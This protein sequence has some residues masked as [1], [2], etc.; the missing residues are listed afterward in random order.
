MS[1][2][3]AMCCYSKKC[4]MINNVKHKINNKQTNK[5][6]KEKPLV[7]LNKNTTLSSFTHNNT[8][9]FLFFEASLVQ[10]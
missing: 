3:V 6:A 4:E 8:G 5:M 2:L 10:V 9:S 1:L 7:G